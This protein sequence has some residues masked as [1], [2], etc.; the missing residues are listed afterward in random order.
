[1]DEASHKEGRMMDRWW[2]P[3]PNTGCWLWL[4]AM[5]AS[6][7]GARFPGPGEEK[8]AHREMYRRR[9]GPIPVGLVLD[10]LCRNPGC[11]NPSHLEPVT[12]RENTLR[13]LRG[14]L[15]THCAH[16]HP[17]TAENLWLDRYSDGRP[18]CRRCRTCKLATNRATKARKRARSSA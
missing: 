13:G 14:R 16:G 11:V 15:R 2:T 10:H 6:G 9:V 8:M 1:M 4:G 12:P 7:H 5:N 3:E 18:A 17:Y